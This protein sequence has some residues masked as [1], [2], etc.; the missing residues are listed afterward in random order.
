ML[1]TW[2]SRTT[3]TC[4]GPGLVVWSSLE[5]NINLSWPSTCSGYVSPLAVNRKW[6][7]SQGLD[8]SIRTFQATITVSDFWC[9][10]FSPNIE[11]ISDFAEI[12]WRVFVSSE[13]LY[14][15][16]ALFLR[17][18]ELIALKRLRFWDPEWIYL[19]YC[20]GRAWNSD[21]QPEEKAILKIK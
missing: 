2:K 15:E 20:C 6:Y 10:C 11:V 3:S 16:A 19:K 5:P 21:V 9:F 7:L 1:N 4:L 8:L 12:V 17:Y 18:K 14:E 13:Y